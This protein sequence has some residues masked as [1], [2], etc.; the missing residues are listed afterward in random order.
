M[1]KRR[2]G[3]E[4]AAAEVLDVVPDGEDVAF[5]NADV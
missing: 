4:F 1:A 3:Y 2:G 5:E